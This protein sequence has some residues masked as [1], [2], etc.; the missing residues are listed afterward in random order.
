MSMTER[1]NLTSFIGKRVKAVYMRADTGRVHDVIEFDDGSVIT[2]NPDNL[3][4]GDG[5]CI[6]NDGNF[7][8]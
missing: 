6:E 8:P 7:R 1:I 4:D 5:M 2:A 3:F